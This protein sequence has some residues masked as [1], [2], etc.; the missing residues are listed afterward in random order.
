MR[1]DKSRS[2]VGYSLILLA[3]LGAI[4][5]VSTLDKSPDLDIS[6]QGYQ[7]AKCGDGLSYYRLSKLYNSE[8]GSNSPRATAFDVVLSN[9]KRARILFDYSTTVSNADFKIKLLNIEN[10]NLNL[11]KTKF[12]INLAGEKAFAEVESVN[13]K[14]GEASFVEI[15]SDLK[16]LPVK[17][18]KASFS[19]SN[20]SCL[21]DIAEIA[22][23]DREN[24]QDGFIRGVTNSDE[25]R[26]LGLN[27]GLNYFGFSDVHL[28]SGL[29]KQ[30]VKV[31]SYNSQKKSWQKANVIEPGIGY[32][33]FGSY[34][35]RR[36]V[37]FG[38]P[39]WSEKNYQA[40]VVQPGW[41]LLYNDSGRD[42]N[43][44]DYKVSFAANEDRISLYDPKPL[45][46][47]SLIDSKNASSDLYLA[48]TSKL[49]KLNSATIPDSSVFWLYIFSNPNGIEL[50]PTGI[51]FKLEGVGDTY[52]PGQVIN[53][54]FVVV[55][56]DSIAHE[57]IS[58]GTKDP[59]TYGIKVTNQ[60]NEVIHNDLSGRNCPNWPNVVPLQSREKINY[61]YSWRVPNYAS[62][63]YKVEAYFDVYRGVLG[64]P[65]KKESL[66]NIK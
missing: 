27:A 9:L 36:D 19:L 21:V 40:R 6:G 51:D 59:C 1:N 50:K 47:S 8:S 46:I 62:G 41:N 2:L 12:E 3:S 25:G 58:S 49:E 17:N 29:E 13:L 22:T 55:N 30:G 57:V 31:F 35:R 61:N 37:V 23:L 60:R 48:S 54:N 7:E 38:N 24:H 66:I 45:S 11:E 15:E 43:I 20:G 5:I 42:I 16:S 64:D 32:V 14:P 56:L 65:S 63:K 44:K 10:D 34:G 52:K 26:V 28:V 53:F 4:L 18:I 33:A 39:F